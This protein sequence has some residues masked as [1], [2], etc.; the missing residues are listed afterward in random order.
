MAHALIGGG[1]GSGKS[2]FL[3]DIIA[4]AAWLYSPEELQFILLDMKSVEFG[5][6]KHLPNVQVLSTKSEKAY[7][8]NLLSYVCGEINRRK[9][10]FGD[11]GCKDIKEYNSGQHKIP[12]ILVVIDE[13]QNLFVQEGAIGNLKEANLSKK[14]ESAFNVILKEGRAFGIHF[15]LATQN[16]SD[17]PNQRYFPNAGQ[18][19]PSR[20]TE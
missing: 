15:I 12:R 13:F 9:R 18:S 11:A 10:M 2:T 14:I 7:G 17:I 4:N 5:I 19:S 16:A 1:T 8:A 6:Y 20:Q 3:H